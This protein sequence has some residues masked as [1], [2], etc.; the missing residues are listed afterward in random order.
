RR[1]RFPHDLTILRSSA[2]SLFSSV[3]QTISM[4]ADVRW[5]HEFFPYWINNLLPTEIGRALDVCCGRG[6]AGALLKV[7]RDCYVEGI[8]AWEPSAS[9]ART[10]YDRVHVGEALKT[11]AEIPDKSF[12]V[13]TMFDAIEHFERE[14]AFKMLRHLERVGRTVYISSVNWFYQQPEFEGNPYQQH[15]CLI[16]SL[17]M[18]ERGYQ[19]VGWGP[20]VE[21]YGP[22]F[23]HFLRHF[24]SGWLAWKN[25][26]VT[27]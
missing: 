4:S 19:V 17:E 22:F 23:R 5:T 1:L 21:R 15:R 12:D 26:P 2:N 10:F 14:N 16:T 7:Y 9:F 6:P 13:V 25:N 20:F 24:A 8:E 11:I 18:T 3:G 27:R